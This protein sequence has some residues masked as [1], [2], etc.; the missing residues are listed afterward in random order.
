[1]TERLADRRN[2]LKLM[3]ITAGSA[4]LAACAPRL[5]RAIADATVTPNP[6]LTIATLDGTKHPI[7]STP[8]NRSTLAVPAA[9]DE[10]QMSLSQQV[11][12]M[13]KENFFTE[14]LNNNSETIITPQFSDRQYGRMT[15][16]V[17]Q[18]NTCGPATIATIAKMYQY[19]KTGKVPDIRIVDVYNVLDG[20]T[21][22]DI[23][24]WEDKYIVSDDQMNYDGFPDALN[25][26]IPG[27][28]LITEF[29]TPDYGAR[30]SPLFPQSHWP[31]A[32]SKAQKICQKGGSVVLRGF[33]KDD[34][35]VRHILLATGVK[36]DG[37]ATFVDSY[38]GAAKRGVLKNYFESLVDPDAKS[39]GEQPGLLDMIGIT[40]K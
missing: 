2:F 30:Y 1:M 29:L 12:L 22:K 10:W 32:L 25:L 14:R 20:Q 16:K 26:V 7:R 13:A 11:E 23:R 6:D 8:Y 28:T 40:P 37:T 35:P 21:F 38:D 34:F 4:A 17:F 15:R 33:K 3:A 31:D 5:S 27:S 19:L 36:N 24:G 9:P 39:L 18:N